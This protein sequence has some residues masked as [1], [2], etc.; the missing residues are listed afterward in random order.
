[1]EL[2]TVFLLFENVM[3]EGDYL[4]GVYADKESANK[5]CEFVNKNIPGRRCA[6]YHVE[7]HVIRYS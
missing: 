1:M 5:Q 7:E 3:R 4:K 2:K 6:F